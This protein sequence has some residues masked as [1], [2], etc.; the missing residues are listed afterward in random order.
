MVNGHREI[1]PC[2]IK[3]RNFWGA[4]VSNPRYENPARQT[5]FIANVNTWLVRLQYWFYEFAHSTKSTL[6]FKHS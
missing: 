6:F 4:A 1:D 5:I 3:S 2:V